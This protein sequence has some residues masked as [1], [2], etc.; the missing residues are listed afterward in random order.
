MKTKLNPVRSLGQTPKRRINPVGKLR[1]RGP[2]S[3]WRRL[4]IPCSLLLAASCSQPGRAAIPEPD[5][6][7]Y[8]Q[9]FLGT[10]HITAQ[11]TNIL[12]EV[13][14]PG[15]T[16]VLSRYRM[17]ENAAYGSL[18]VVEIHLGL[19]AVAPGVAAPT[20]GS[21]L[22]LVVKEG[23]VERAKTN[24]IVGGGT[25]TERA[26]VQRID[27]GTNS[28]IGLDAWLVAYGLDAGTGDQDSDRDGSS[29]RQ[30]YLAG[31]SPTNAASKFLLRIAHAQT[32]AEV[33]FDAV[34]AEGTGY[35]GLA[36]HY[37][38]ERL[39]NLSSTNWQTMPGYA[40]I[41]G[42]NQVVVCTTPST[43]APVFFRG[44]VW[45]D[46]S[47][48]AADE[49]RLWVS[50]ADGQMVVSFTALGPDAQ[51]RNRYYTLERSPNLLGGSWI[52]VPG[53]SN[54]L[55]SRQTVTHSVSNLG[56]GPGFYRGR[57]ELR[58]P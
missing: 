48:A 21:V 57:L 58:N 6:V 45:L 52:A 18:Y 46:A 4:I 32:N 26:Y 55:G 39:S 50:D 7:A 17:G 13:R 23:G 19:G 20:N 34:R 27:F 47:D 44:K 11:H 51:G 53:C 38:L 31:T 5:N 35:A 28:L 15:A 8:G 40:D 30:E 1:L 42:A 22:D 10:N 2:M 43:G 3:L 14:P 29:N 24:F 37:A 49:F 16:N 36:R 41:V 54:V 56:S 33:A 12:I 25:Q 9:I